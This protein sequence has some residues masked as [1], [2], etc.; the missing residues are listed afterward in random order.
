MTTVRGERGSGTLLML[1]VGLLVLLSG[2][3]VVL[4]AAISTAH[5]RRASRRTWRR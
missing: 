3:A 1:S 5:H 2:L 4:W